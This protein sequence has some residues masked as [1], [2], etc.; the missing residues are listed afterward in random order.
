MILFVFEVVLVFFGVSYPWQI[1]CLDCFLLSSITCWIHIMNRDAKMSLGIR[2]NFSKHS[3]EIGT[4]TYL[5]SSGSICESHFSESFSISKRIVKILYTHSIEMPTVSAFSP[6]RSL[7]KKIADFFSHLWCSNPNWTT[8]AFFVK[9][10]S[11]LN[12]KNVTFTH[13]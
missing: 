12:I 10:I 4:Q 3:F 1:H 11:R 8:W 6:L 7:I 13:E 2:F 9:N 5:M